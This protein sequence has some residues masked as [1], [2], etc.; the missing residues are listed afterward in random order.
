MNGNTDVTANYEITY[1]KGV[2]E[3]TANTKAI[4][5]TSATKSWEYD[6]ELHKE[7]VYTVTYGGETVAA[8]GTGLVFRLPTRDVITITPTEDGV[9]YVSDNAE[10]NNT[11]SYTVTK[12]TRAVENDVSDQY[13]NLTTEFGTLS[14]TKA[15]LTITADSDSK[16]YD[17]TPLTDSGWQDTAP[18]G[19]KGTDDITSVTVT[20][21]ITQVGT[22]D[23]VPSDAVVRNGDLNVTE[24]YNI[25]SEKGVLEIT[26]STKALV[27]S[28]ATRSWEYDGELHTEEVYSV[29]FE[30]EPI[31]PDESGRIF[32]LSTGDTIEITP[33]AEGVRYVS[34]SVEKNNTF[35]YELTNEEGY[36]SVSVAFGTLSITKAPLTITADSASK[37]YDE[38]PLTDDG[39]QDSPPEGLKGTDEVTS[40]TVTG[41]IT[42][43]G[44]E[45]NVPSDAVVMNGDVDVTDNYEISYV[46]GILKVIEPIAPD[47]GDYGMIPVM[48]LG[49]MSLS[50]AITVAIGGRKSRKENE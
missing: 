10:H 34:D 20:G 47:T 24:N 5:I 3:I 17:G 45:D 50:M 28:S 13:S 2:L 15:P 12:G 36:K 25:T 19:L 49:I 23:N 9:T 4:V 6:G 48:L 27:I 42:E 32:T 46:N 39:G 11:F 33:T 41:S 29:T 44:T 22:E 38:T 21:T 40:V 35:S 26:K 8:D 18:V 31:L 1:E 30:G 37:E 7:E 14:I 43:I 16:E